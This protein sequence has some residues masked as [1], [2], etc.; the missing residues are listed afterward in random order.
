MKVTDVLESIGQRPELKKMV[1][2]DAATILTQQLVPSNLQ[3]SLLLNDRD[4][5][6]KLAG[7]RQDIICYIAS[8]E[9][10]GDMPKDGNKPPEEDEPLNEEAILNKAS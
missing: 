10:E 1:C 2:T 4:T 5:L 9:K 6:E 7:F 8:P 3:K